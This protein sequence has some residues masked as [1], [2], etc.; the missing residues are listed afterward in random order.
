MSIESLLTPG[1]LYFIHEIDVLSGDF[2]PYTKIG[3]VKLERESTKRKKEHQTGNPRNLVLAHVIQTDCVSSAENYLHWRYVS[4]GVRGEWF[5][6]NHQQLG[7]AVKYAESIRDDFASRISTL[8]AGSELSNVASD[9]SMQA[10]S[11]EA[12]HW[13]Y[14]YHVA[15]VISA[16][17]DK[18]RALFN[19]AMKDAAREGIDVSSAGSVRSIEKPTFDKKAFK[20]AEP[21]LWAEFSLME[22]KSSFST[23]HAGES[24]RADSRTTSA[25]VYVTAL[26]QA[27]KKLKEG[28]LSFDEVSQIDFAVLAATNFYGREKELAR[29]HLQSIC[30]TAGG[31]EGVLKWDRKAEPVFNINLLKDQNPEMY[32]KYSKMTVHEAVTRDGTALADSADDVVF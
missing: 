8:R 21:A 10:P 4:L 18:T 15:H 11:D 14:E 3:I 25:A 17:A 5:K 28:S 22:V 26:F 12:R 27:V 19:N 2:S 29:L 30:G 1:E 31:I 6:F 7:E 9:E 23:G 20:E 16:D 32:K 24:A 13:Q